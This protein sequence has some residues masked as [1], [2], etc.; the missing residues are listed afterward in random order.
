MRQVFSGW[1]V[2]AETKSRQGMSVLRYDY[3]TRCSNIRS[4]LILWRD[5]SSYVLSHYGDAFLIR[6]LW[7]DAKRAV[8]RNYVPQYFTGTCL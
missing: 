2:A 6:R 4:H 1:G 3:R 7:P 5:I 8:S